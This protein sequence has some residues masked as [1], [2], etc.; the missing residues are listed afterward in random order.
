MTVDID[1]AVRL[2]P[3]DVDRL[4]EAL[5]AGYFVSREAALSAVR[6]HDSLNLVHLESAQK[7]DR[8]VL[9]GDLLDRSQLE[10]R[11]RIPVTEEGD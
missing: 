4:I 2:T 1:I 9:G 3:R 10:R 8:L 11:H 7:V 6:R 5:G